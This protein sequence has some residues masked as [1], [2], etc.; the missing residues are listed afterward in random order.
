MMDVDTAASFALDVPSFLD[1]ASAFSCL[2]TGCMV[3]G[4]CKSVEHVL[5]GLRVPKVVGLGLGIRGPGR[6]RGASRRKHRRAFKR[7]TE[8]DIGIATLD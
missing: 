8:G 4:S 1:L 7:S 2:R 6:Q 3:C 5:I